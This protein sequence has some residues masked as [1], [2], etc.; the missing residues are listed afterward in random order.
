MFSLHM[1]E[2]PTR[3]TDSDDLLHKTIYRLDGPLRWAIKENVQLVRRAEVQSGWQVLDV[4]CGTGY[5]SIPLAETVQPDGKVYCLD[6]DARLQALIESKAA[7][8]GLESTVELVCSDSSDIPFPDNYFDAVLSSYL[9][10]ELA[11]QAPHT[12]K[13]ICR[14]LKPNHKFALA[15]YRRL[16]NKARWQEIESWY[17]A[18]QS[19]IGPEE[20][21]LRFSVVELEQMLYEAGFRYVELSTW[22]EFHMHADA[23]K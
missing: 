20:I 9:L 2:V 14:V 21:R 12:L 19:A 3:S 6:R 18:Q 17:G 8:K 1:N 13:E 16:E 22:C 4:G 11:D 10:H 7:A 23:V 15:D 5:L